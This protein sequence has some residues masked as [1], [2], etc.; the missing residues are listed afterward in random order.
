LCLLGAFLTWW[1]KKCGIV[2][3]RTSLFQMRYFLFLIILFLFSCG[4]SKKLH[5]DYFE[6]YHGFGGARWHFDKDGT[7]SESENSEGDRYFGNGKY[8]INGDSI[9]LIYGDVL[10]KDSSG[11][12]IKIVDQNESQNGVAEIKVEVIDDTTKESIP[13]AVI[14][15]KDSSGKNLAGTSTDLY[16]N[17]TLHI[18]NYAGALTISIQY[19]SY[20]TTS[21]LLLKPYNCTLKASLKSADPKIIEPHAENYR[22]KKRP[23]NKLIFQRTSIDSEVVDKK[24]KIFKP[25]YY[26]KIDKRNCYRVLVKK[27][28]N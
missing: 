15:A 17:A 13:F 16:G 12:I 6:S 23:M 11:S 14:Q 24:Y 10:S 26:L 22:F 4:I 8:I 20:A 5:G 3:G 2:M 1:Q 9:Q 7:F 21:C 27:K 19:I 18:T 25:Y 28:N